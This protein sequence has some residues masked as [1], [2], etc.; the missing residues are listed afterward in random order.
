MDNHTRRQPQKILQKANQPAVLEKMDQIIE[1]PVA[2]PCKIYRGIPLLPFGVAYPPNKTE[3]EFLMLP[4]TNSDQGLS[5]VKFEKL[6]EKSWHY[7][8]EKYKLDEE[9][10]QF[11]KKF[12][13]PR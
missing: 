1:K 6:N 9:G 8:C 4:P 11:F 12:A 10:Q 3:M 5:L 13:S 2:K 7:V